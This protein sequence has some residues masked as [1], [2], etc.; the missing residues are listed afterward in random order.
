M[1]FLFPAFSFI[2]FWVPALGIVAMAI[3]GIRRSQ[4][5]EPGARVPTL[6][7]PGVAFGLSLLGTLGGVFMVSLYAVG[8]GLGGYTPRAEAIVFNAS[9]LSPIVVA[10]LAWLASSVWLVKAWLGRDARP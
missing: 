9:M 2:V 5:R 3:R 10:G 4:R 7:A 8:E 1:D 6:W